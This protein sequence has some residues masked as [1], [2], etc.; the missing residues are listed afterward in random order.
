MADHCRRYALSDP[1][2]SD[3][4]SACNHQHDNIFDRCTML[5]NTIKRLEEALEKQ[6]ENLTEDYVQCAGTSR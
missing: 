5:T 3:Y 4:Q 2:D 6:S 1:D